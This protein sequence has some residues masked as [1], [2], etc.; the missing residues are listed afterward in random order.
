M[1]E[2]KHTPGPWIKDGGFIRSGVNDIHV[3]LTT[4]HEKPAEE[5]DANQNLIA[6][7]PEMLDLFERIM[8]IRGLWYPGDDYPEH[9]AQALAS[10]DI[11]IRGIIKKAKGE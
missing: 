5:R 6:A 9:E 3:C 11:E 4:L 2:S 8:K 1:S 7:A 10:M